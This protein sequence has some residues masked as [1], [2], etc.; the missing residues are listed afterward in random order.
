MEHIIERIKEYLAAKEPMG[1]FQIRGEWG[2]GKTYFFKHI[3]PDKI[4]DGTKKNPEIKRV[5]VIISLFGINRVK[6]IPYRLLN[7][8]VNKLR[9]LDGDI[10]ESMNRGLDYIDIK[11]GSSKGLLDI[12]L[13]DEDELIYSIIHRDDVYICLDDVERFVKEDNVEELMGLINNL[14]ENVGY[15]VF[16]ISNDHYHGMNNGMKDVFT[17]FKEK[18][19]FTSVNYKADLRSIYDGIVDGYEDNDFSL[20]M[21]TCYLFFDPD[22]HDRTLSKDFVNIRNMKFAIKIFYDV[23]CHY[24]NKIDEK[25]TRAKLHNLLAFIVGV[26]IEYKKGFLLDNNCRTID[27]YTDMI[28]LNLG[29]N[30]DVDTAQLFNDVEETSDEKERRERE[31]KFN[32]IYSKR[33]YKYYI[34]DIGLNAVFFQPLY[35]NIVNASTIDYNSLDDIYNKEIVSK[36]INEGNK[37]VAQTLDNTIF[38]YSDEE[39][40]E[41]MLELLKSVDESTLNQCPAYINAFTFLDM[42]KTVIGLSHEVLIER[43]KKGIDGYF[44]KAKISSLERSGIEMVKDSI[45]KGTMEIYEY[46]LEKLDAKDEDEQNKGIEEM[47]ELFNTDIEKF[48]G[49]FGYQNNNG[50]F[51]YVTSAVLQNIPQPMVEKRMLTVNAKDV[52]LLALLISQRY[53]PQDIYS[54]HLQEEVLFLTAMQRGI[55]AIAGDDTLTKVEAKTVLMSHINKAIRSMGIATK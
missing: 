30:D 49:L 23:F 16:I 6:D 2:S 20:F 1:A 34:K 4:K 26:S 33:F 8:Y 9:S 21:K 24:K 12:D 39:G 55:D 40:K 13:Q 52:H 51:R 28:N 35:D 19:I 37:I 41:K 15:K 31:E 48:C 29:D 42:Y 22:H 38:N 47:I 46:L 10:T 11:Y 53:T 50:C 17:T 3:L 14:V 25:P 54:Y 45:M 32:G 7:A 18:V 27:T 44:R 36:E 5:P 43:F